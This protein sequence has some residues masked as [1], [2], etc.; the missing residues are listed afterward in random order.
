MQIYVFENL[1]AYIGT[2]KIHV[3]KHT[4]KNPDSLCGS[5]IYAHICIVLFVIL[6]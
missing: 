4:K 6:K 3:E 5:K 2:Q 1:K